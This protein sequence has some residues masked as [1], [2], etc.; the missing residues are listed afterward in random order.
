MSQTY[1]PC[2]YIITGMHSLYTTKQ[3]R[4]VTSDELLCSTMSPVTNRPLPMTHS[5]PL[6]RG[7]RLRHPGGLK[8]HRIKSSSLHKHCSTVT[9][10]GPDH[11]SMCH[12]KKT[13]RHE[14]YSKKLGQEAMKR[15]VRPERSQQLCVQVCARVWWRKSCVSC[16]YLRSRLKVLI[17]A[18]SR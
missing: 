4:S 17:S 12:K 14:G 3:Q 18:V 2:V 8:Q 16:E 11:P 1:F 10:Y 6:H 5:D 7:E 15:R 13:E 9:V